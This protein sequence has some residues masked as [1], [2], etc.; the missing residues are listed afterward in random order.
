MQIKVSDLLMHNST[1]FFQV[2]CKTD[3]YGTFRQ[4]VVFDF[5]TE[6]VLVQE[7]CVDSTS[8]TD[9]DKLSQDLMLSNSGR[10]DLANIDVI[11]F[12]PR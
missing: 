5:G 8:V 10:W 4:S 11:D 12:E 9:L 7:L 2:I 3:I 1:H 6:P